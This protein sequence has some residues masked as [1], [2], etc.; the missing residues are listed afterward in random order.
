MQTYR[1]YFML[2]S[3]V[4]IVASEATCAETQFNNLEFNS[5]DIISEFSEIADWDSM[6]DLSTGEFVNAWGESQSS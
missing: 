1:L 4:D 2:P 6:E 3:Y 5:E